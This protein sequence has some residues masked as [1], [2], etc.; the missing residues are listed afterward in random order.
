MNKH[1]SE[2]IQSLYQN[3][4]KVYEDISRLEEQWSNIFKDLQYGLHDIREP[5]RNIINFCELLDQES[6]KIA[7][8]EQVKMYIGKIQKN[9]LFLRKMIEDL[10]YIIARKCAYNVNGV[11]EKFNVSDVITEAINLLDKNEVEVIIEKNL[12]SVFGIYDN[13]VKVF[14]NLISNSI[15]Y[16]KSNKCRI[17]IWGQ[18]ENIYYR[19]NGIGIPKDKWEAVF[20]L[21]V[22]ISEY[23]DM[24]NGTGVG[25]YVAKQFLEWDNY[26]IRIESSILYNKRGHGT[27]FYIYRI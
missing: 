16:N 4:K 21:F 7:L 8:P 24:C 20:K 2:E 6:K 27:T 23:S 14:M 1:I 9:S 3:I 18:D 25:L 17:R 10:S 22:R 5:L 15:K 26:S 11:K 13:W 19:D 12:P